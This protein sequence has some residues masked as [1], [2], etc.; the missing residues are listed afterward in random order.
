MTDTILKILDSMRE[1]REKATPGPWHTKK[2]ESQ[3][4]LYHK[5]EKF[6]INQVG[7]INDIEFIAAARSEHAQLEEALRVAVNELFE[8]RKAMVL[9][10]DGQIEVS[11]LV[12]VAID[13]DAQ[14]GLEQIEKIL[15]G[16]K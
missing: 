4:D 8:L 2:N 1:R 7:Y 11:R 15:K 3:I 9:I 16:D 12:F 6:M 14:S 10:L 5:G 13:K